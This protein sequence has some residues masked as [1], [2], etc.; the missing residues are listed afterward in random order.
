VAGLDSIEPNI[1]PDEADHLATLY[2]IAAGN[3][4]GIFDLSWDGNPAASL[5][6]ALPFLTLFGPSYLSLR[7]STVVGSLLTLVVFFAL[8][9]CRLSVFASLAATTLLAFSGWYL[10]FSRNGE[11]NVWV[12][13]YA[14]SAAYFT[15]R[16]IEGSRWRDWI[17]AGIFCGLGWYSYLGGVFILPA[18]LAY[19]LAAPRPPT[20]DDRRPRIEASSAVVGGRR[21]VV[22]GRWSVVGRL[23]GCGV[24]IGVSLIMLLQ[25]LPALIEHY[26]AVE[27]YVGER[28]VLSDV[29]LAEAPGILVRQFLITLRVF[30]LMDSL[31]V[32]N[33]RYIA[34]QAS[35]LDPLAGGLYL[36]GLAL[37]LRC[38]RATALW[39]CLFVPF[40]FVVQP[41]SSPIPDAARALPALPAMMLFAGLTVDRLTRAPP[42]ARQLAW[43]A[44]VLVLV[45]VPAV[46]YWNWSR[47]VEWQRQPSNAAVRQPAVE[48]SEFPTWQTLQM[49]EARAGRRGFTVTDWHR[50]RQNL[51]AASLG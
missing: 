13:L 2:Q 20:T 11:V 23:K 36:V 29:D 33:T 15:Q 16:A 28:S 5:Y 26:P 30:V 24:L 41:L 34:P 50:M 1:M 7:L 38:L 49:A 18:M 31:L 39:W 27:R 46:S 40:I 8:A 32:G 48:M 42:M 44:A 47:Y 35:V 3:G 17:V 14:L 37:S 9:R 4:P 6:P 19:V 22:H 43:A 10:F 45:A 21:S 12:L 51:P 25:R